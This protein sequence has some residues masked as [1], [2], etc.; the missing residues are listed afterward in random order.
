LAAADCAEFEDLPGDADA[1]L[2]EA[3][4]LVSFAAVGE[5]VSPD[6]IVAKLMAA[7]IRMLVRNW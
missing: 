2:S 1:E 3:A 7:R 4:M 6:E 5:A